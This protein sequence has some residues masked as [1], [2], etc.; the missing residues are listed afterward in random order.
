MATFNFSDC[1]KRQQS[2]NSLSNWQ[3]NKNQ[4][5]KTKTVLTT[6]LYQ[7]PEHWNCIKNR[8]ICQWIDYFF[9]FYIVYF[10]VVV[11]LFFPFDLCVLCSPNSTNNY[12]PPLTRRYCVFFMKKKKI[13]KNRVIVLHSSRSF[14]DHLCDRVLQSFNVVQVKSSVDQVNAKFCT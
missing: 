5:K 11:L 14:D 13:N 4:I 7:C 9:T 2:N 3:T 6:N 10:A 12:H 8:I 1:L